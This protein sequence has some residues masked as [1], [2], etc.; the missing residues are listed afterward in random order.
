MHLPNG[1]YRVA[2]PSITVRL[3]PDISST[4]D[5]QALFGEDVEVLATSG[6]F[7]R[8]H[9]LND[10]KKGWIDSPTAKLS[11]YSSPLPSRTHRVARPR[12]IAF[13]EPDAKTEQAVMLSMNSKLTIRGRQTGPN[14]DFGEVIGLAGGESVWVRM[15]GLMPIRTFFSDFVAVQEMYLGV[16][17]KW[18][19]RDACPGMD[20]SGLDGAGLLASGWDFCPRDTKDQVNHPLF[21]EQMDFPSRGLGLERGDIIFFRGHVVTMV[22]TKRCIHATD[23]EPHHAVV[24]QDLNEVIG[25]R[26]AAGLGTPVTVRRLRGYRARRLK[27]AA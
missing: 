21:G 18:A 23:L 24:I 27:G 20:C 16:L 6:P 2:V 12:I 17:Y 4:A 19:S 8:I 11:S 3:E 26:I 9:V 22:D 7:A 10:G 13:R 25:Q 1:Q 15:N 14:G 5:D